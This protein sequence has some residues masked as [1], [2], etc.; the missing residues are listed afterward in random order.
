[1]HLGIINYGTRAK[2]R[3]VDQLAQCLYQ[4]G[5]QA[6]IVARLPKSGERITEFNN[7]PILQLPLNV[8]RF[9]YLISA[10]IPLNWI[11]TRWIVYFARKY[12]WQAIFVIEV[13][14][15]WQV[16]RAAKI[17]DIPA[18]LDMRENLGAM[19]AA[20]S[21]ERLIRK[22]L[23]PKRFVHFYESLVVPKFNHVFTVSQELRIWVTE[24]YKIKPN[25][26]SVLSNYPSQVFLE[27]AEK[28]AKKKIKRSHEKV[29][30]LVHTGFVKKDRGLQDILKALRIL[31]DREIN[32]A[33]RIIGDG[34]N[35]NDL[36]ELVSQLGIEKHVEFLPM[37]PP[38]NVADAL[39]D[40][41][42]GLCSY[43][44]NEHTQQTL[45]GKL[46]EY[47]A[48]GLP[49]LSSAR[50]PVISII[51]KEK[52]GFIYYSRDP[53]AIANAIISLTKDLNNAREM[54]RRGREAVIKRYNQKSNLEVLRKVLEK[55]NTV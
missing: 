20:G 53:E 32:V 6:L 28:A 26:I 12:S 35:L 43:L 44:L 13:P 15:A 54:G 16:L 3:G 2:N 39:A 48:V 42:V 4:L 24:N 18:Y 7:I 14:L 29:L 19:Y 41:D 25:V 37:L 55:N 22:F 17:L 10:P 34:T 36:K 52:C 27:Q 46:F 49:V 50:K 47:M 1:M 51:E 45:P 31:I 21:E 11:W 5:H 33:L 9:G 23:R 38:E 40:C 30:K 8:K